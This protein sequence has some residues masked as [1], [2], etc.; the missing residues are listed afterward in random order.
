L[1]KITHPVER[2][3]TRTRYTGHFLT[4]TQWA[5]KIVRDGVRWPLT[6]PSTFRPGT[7]SRC[8][9]AVLHRRF[10]VIE[11]DVLNKDEMCAVISR[12]RQFMELRA[13]VDTAGKSLHAWFDYPDDDA[14]AELKIILP[15]IGCDPALFKASQ[16]CRLPG[17]PRGD[18]VQSLLWFDGGHGDE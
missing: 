8:N 9:E 2:E 14:I 17:A 18:K 10:L 1:A 15:A 4:P 7:Y 11:S 12:C 5:E 3:Q 16:P 6:C 13:V